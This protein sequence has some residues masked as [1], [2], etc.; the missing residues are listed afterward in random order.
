MIQKKLAKFSPKISKIV[1]NIKTHV[2]KYFPIFLS[3]KITD[4]GNLK[5]YSQVTT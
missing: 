3:I 4:H 1:Y 2:S 5:T